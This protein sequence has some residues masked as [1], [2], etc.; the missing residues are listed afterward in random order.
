MTSSLAPLSCIPYLIASRDIAF[1]S[2]SPRAM[3]TL[4]H[5]HWGEGDGTADK[6]RIGVFQNPFSG[7]E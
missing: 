5:P 1:I 6:R 2:A 7:G 3:L 4:L